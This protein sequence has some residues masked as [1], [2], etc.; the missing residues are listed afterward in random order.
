[1]NFRFPLFLAISANVIFAQFSSCRC[2]D[3]PL[4]GDLENKVEYLA[5]K[6]TRLTRMRSIVSG[7]QGLA[8]QRGPAGAPG[9]IKFWA[10]Q[11]VYQRQG[12]RQ[13]F[14]LKIWTKS[15]RDFL[16]RISDRKAKQVFKT[17]T[18]FET[19]TQTVFLNRTGRPVLLEN[20]S[21]V[22]SRIL[23]PS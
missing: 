6:L 7:R 17:E 21:L 18:G 14:W 3:D 19:R 10:R 23:S 13:V 20:L 2:E 5:R 16:C 22:V 4:L 12:Q 8:G 9:L 11:P 1:M 15:N